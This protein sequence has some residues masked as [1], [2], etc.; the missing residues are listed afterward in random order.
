MH[1]R[2]AVVLVCALL[3]GAVPLAWGQPSPVERDEPPRADRIALSVPDESGL[4]TITGDTNSTYP[5]AVVGIR[6]L[7][8]GEFTFASASFTGAFAAQL[9]GVPG[10]PFLI[11]ADNDYP[12]RGAQFPAALPGDIGMIVHAPARDDGGFSMA[13]LYEGARWRADIEASSL[14]VETGA[15][16]T[17]QLDVAAAA[18][19]PFDAAL[20]LQPIAIN[21]DG[22][23]RPATVTGSSG[24]VAETTPTGMPIDGIDSTVPLGELTQ[25]PLPD[26][27][28][29]NTRFSLRFDGTLPDDLPTGLYAPLLD[30]PDGGVTRLPMIVRAG[31]VDTV[32]LPVALF[33]DSG[34]DGARGLLAENAVGALSHGARW[35][36][37]D[38][39]LP[40]GSYPIEP[41]LPTQLLNRSDRYTAPLIPLDLPGGE[42]HVTIAQPD[43]GM[44]HLNAAITQ[45]WMGTT[46]E[47]ERVR[48]GGGPTDVYRLTTS[49]PN[50]AAYP[51]D[52]YGAYTITLDLTVADEFGNLYTGGGDYHLLIAEPL[53]L[54]PGLLP[55]APIPAG[56]PVYGGVRI[57]PPVPAEVTAT[58]ETAGLDSVTSTTRLSGRA[59]RYGTFVPANALD[60]DTPG[61]YRLDTSAA[62]TDAKGRLWAGSL[63]SA[64]VITDP[65]RPLIAHGA[66]GAY[67]QPGASAPAR[68]SLR[69][70][71]AQTGDADLLDGAILNQPYYGG[72]IAKTGGSSA[73]GLAFPLRLQDVVG[74]YARWLIETGAV[75]SLSA[76]RGDLPAEIPGYAYA[77][78]SAVTPAVSVRQQ[79]AGGADGGLPAW[80]DAD[81]SLNQQIGAGAAG[82]AAG[83]MVFLF[84]GAVVR[85][86]R[87]EPWRRRQATRDWR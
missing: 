36:G 54:F 38:F 10:N 76:A 25:I 44:V 8:S 4:I 6:N 18:P 41:Y 57:S 59:S 66:R 50:F 19:E 22:L 11:Q 32:P 73:Y 86:R 67:E 1:R 16:W 65:S 15:E 85:A 72:G 64:G 47:D 43:G 62:Y 12:A 84:G 61:E 69:G 34:T 75:D 60:N 45:N 58:L 33:M 42:L 68:Y 2:C 26:S 7:Y 63:R 31:A 52:Q 30:L 28:D 87:S 74:D 39:I 77:Y 20:R 3:L 56:Q 48:F 5:G 27:E 55:G 79:V 14:D 49:D 83:D 71:A 81:D 40:P 29:G 21:D 78:V 53:Q 9:P 13:G 17:L 37:P 80:V 35:N 46:E 51:F 82:L 70:L 23:M 24:W